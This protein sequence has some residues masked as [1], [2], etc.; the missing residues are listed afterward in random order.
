MSSLARSISLPDY[1]TPLTSGGPHNNPPE[2]SSALEPDREASHAAKGSPQGEKVHQ[3]S[4]VHGARLCHLSLREVGFKGP[5]GVS[6]AWCTPLSPII[7]G[8]WV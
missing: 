6:S 1:D 4:V 3:V 2:V 5:P 8:G 7:E